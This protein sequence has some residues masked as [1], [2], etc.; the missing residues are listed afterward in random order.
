[1]RLRLFSLSLTGEATNWLNELPDDSIRTWAEPKEALLE[2]FFPEAKD[3]QMKDEIGTH[4][5]LPGEEMHDTWWRFSQK[6]KK[7][8]NHGLTEKHLKQAFYRSLN[9]VTKPIIDAV[10]G[11]SFMRKLFLEIMILM[12]SKNNRAWH[13]RA[14]EVGDLG[15]TFEL[16]TE[17]KKWEEQKNQDMAHM[18]NQMDLLTKHIMSGSEKVNIVGALNRYENE[19]NDLDEEAKYLGGSYQREG[20]YERSRNREQGNWKNIDGYKN[21]SGVCIPSRNR[22]RARNSSNGSKME[23]MLAKM[24]QKVESTDAG[25]KEMKSNFSSMSQLVDSHTTSIKQLEQ[26]LGQLSVL[27]NPRKNGSLPSETIQNP[28]KDGQ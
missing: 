5:Q 19:D 23:E 27:L 15:F 1:M 11:E 22:D 3:L 12:V 21:C 16:S 4:K 6:L 28:K 20:K 7:C 26:Q 13:T 18:R 25:I 8:P 24:L 17:Q 2:R 9:F 14:A 10:C